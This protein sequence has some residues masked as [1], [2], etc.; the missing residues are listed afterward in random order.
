MAL[1]LAQKKNPEPRP[2]AYTPA[3]SSLI[4]VVSGLVVLLGW[5]WWRSRTRREQTSRD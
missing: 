2:L 4:L 5:N 1:A 3:P